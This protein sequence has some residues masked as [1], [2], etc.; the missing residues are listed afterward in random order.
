MS[1]HFTPEVYAAT[2]GILC[3]ACGGTT[4]FPG[5]L[6]RRG[7]QYVTQPGRCLHCDATWTA[8]Y[9]L[10]GYEILQSQETQP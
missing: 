7:M 6:S 10:T 3:P 4:V 8:I 1:E 5:Q 9:T 2:G